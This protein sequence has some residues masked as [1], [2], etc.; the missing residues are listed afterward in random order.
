MKLV[1]AFLVL[2][3]FIAGCADGD[4]PSK[5]LSRISVIRESEL[6]PADN[7]INRTTPKTEIQQPKPQQPTPPVTSATPVT[8]APPQQSYSQY[9]VIVASYSAAEKAKAEKMVAKLRSKNY[10]ATLIYSSQRYRISIESFSS[11]V[12]ANAA[13]DD[14]RSITDRQDIWVHKVN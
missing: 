3:C 9:H 4:L 2:G 14:Y 11:E 1:S 5:H 6:T 8:S 10:P 12:E 7:Q 13:R